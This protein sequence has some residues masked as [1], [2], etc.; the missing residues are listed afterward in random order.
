MECLAGERERWQETVVKLDDSYQ[1]LPGDCLLATAFMSYMGPFV[2][3]YREELMTLWQKEVSSQPNK[4]LTHLKTIF[5]IADYRARGVVFP[6]FQ[7]HQF[8]K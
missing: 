5:D 6:K 4:N 8:L 3:N 1:Y 7:L 2:T